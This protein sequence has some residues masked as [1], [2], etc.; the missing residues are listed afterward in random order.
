MPAV[1]QHTAMGCNPTCSQAGAACRIGATLS[2]SGSALEPRPRAHLVDSQPPADQ[3][4]RRNAKARGQ[5]RALQAVAGRAGGRPGP[6]RGRSRGRSKFPCALADFSTSCSSLCCLAELRFA[7]FKTSRS[8]VRNPH[9]RPE[10]AKIVQAV[11]VLSRTLGVQTVAE[12]VQTE[13]D[14]AAVRHLGCGLAK[15]GLFGRPMPAGQ[16]A[17]LARAGLAGSAQQAPDTASRV[18]RAHAEPA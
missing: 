5:V 6:R 10:S 8:F 16:V 3:A 15:G 9:D 4:Q 2:A 17:T 7:K 14:A 11:I 12:G 18:R 13:R 1:G